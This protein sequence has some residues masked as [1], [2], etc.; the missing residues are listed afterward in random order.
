MSFNTT[1]WLLIHQFSAEN[2][3]CFPWVLVVLFLAR[4]LVQ[5]ALAQSKC[6]APGYHMGS[7]N[8]FTQAE[9]PSLFSLSRAEISHV[10]ANSVLRR[11]DW[12]GR[13]SVLD[14]LY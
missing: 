13:M 6:L 1:K 8:P 10:I 5:T 12:R 9:D 7:I 14:F 4:N 11:D 3:L 2:F